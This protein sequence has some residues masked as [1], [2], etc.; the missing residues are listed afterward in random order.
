MILSTAVIF[1]FS[2]VSSKNMVNN[3]QDFWIGN[4][5]CWGNTTSHAKPKHA[6]LLANEGTGQMT[7]ILLWDNPKFYFSAVAGI[8]RQICY[9]HTT[10][11]MEG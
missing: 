10:L 2:T 4:F 9:K 6:R 1:L 7:L 5:Y 3:L 11:Q 8:R